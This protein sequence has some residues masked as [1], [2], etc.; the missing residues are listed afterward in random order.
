M[1]KISFILCTLLAGSVL[2]HAA[3]Q[4]LEQTTYSDSIPEV[5]VTGARSR[6][7]IRHLSQTVSIISRNAIEQSHQSSLLPLLTEQVP[8]YSLPPAV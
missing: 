3:Q 7:D 2:A 4:P 6:T 8:D 5:V 1:R